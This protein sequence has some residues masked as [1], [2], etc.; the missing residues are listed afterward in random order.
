LSP[1]KVP[2]DELVAKNF[3]AILKFLG[4][5]GCRGGFHEFIITSLVFVDGE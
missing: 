5:L 4:I 2:G 1:G 3:Q